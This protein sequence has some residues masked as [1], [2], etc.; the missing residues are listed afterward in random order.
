M[1]FIQVCIHPTKEHVGVI[2]PCDIELARKIDQLPKADWHA[3]E[4]TFGFDGCRAELDE[5]PIKKRIHMS[6]DDYI[7]LVL[8]AAKAHG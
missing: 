3:F 2:V 5:C 8:E 1:S 7:K 6:A 4:A